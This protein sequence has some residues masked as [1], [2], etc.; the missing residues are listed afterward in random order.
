MTINVKYVYNP[1]MIDPKSNGAIL[2]L[3]NQNM[4]PPWIQSINATTTGFDLVSYWYQS[5]AHNYQSKIKGDD[6]QPVYQNR[7]GLLSYSK[8]YRVSIL[9]MVYFFSSD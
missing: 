7:E 4:E 1:V 2:N 9:T 6:P 8:Q 3:F 5:E